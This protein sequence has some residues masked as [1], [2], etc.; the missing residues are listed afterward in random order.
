MALI[1]GIIITI[2]AT[3]AAL[4]VSSRLEITAQ[5]RQ[6]KQAYRAALSGIEDALLLIKQA[7]L[8]GQ[9]SLVS[10][11]TKSNI[12]ISP[13]ASD[14]RRASYDLQI[15]SDWVS[16]FPQSYRT[17]SNVALS[18][19]LTSLNYSNAATSSGFGEKI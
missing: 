10:S 4:I 13:E 1:V 9:M 18:S 19:K 7:R 12:E 16:S 17:F 14:K 15:N 5:S 6:G 3:S 11:L 8:S 2:V